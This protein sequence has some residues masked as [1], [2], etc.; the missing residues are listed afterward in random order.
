MMYEIIYVPRLRMKSQLQ[1][2]PQERSTEKIVTKYVKNKQPKV[3]DYHYIKEIEED[4][5]G[6]VFADD[7][8]DEVQKSFGYDK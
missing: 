2:I 6:E 4:D 1:G 8:E 5:R 3:F 7:I